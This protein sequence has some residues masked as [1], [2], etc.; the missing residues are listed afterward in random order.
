GRRGGAG[1]GWPGWGLCPCGGRVVRWRRRPGPGPGTAPG[2]KNS[3]S[4]ATRYGKRGHVFL[5]TVT[6][7]ALVI[8]LRS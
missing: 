5:G 1:L 8:W 3:R 7:A 6:A 4:V 2:L